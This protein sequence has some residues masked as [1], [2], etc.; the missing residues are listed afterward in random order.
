MTGP[1]VLAIDQATTGSTCL[2]LDE[3]GRVCGRGYREIA[4]HYPQP[5]WVEHVPAELL[6][7]TLAWARDDESGR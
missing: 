1:H 5:G 6:S 4:Q 3:T 2:V 7:R